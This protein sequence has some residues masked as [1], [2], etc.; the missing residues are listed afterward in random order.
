MNNNRLISKCMKFYPT[1][2]K[3]IFYKGMLFFYSNNILMR[4]NNPRF[5]Y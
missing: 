1:A 3:S 4:M 2:E 5:H